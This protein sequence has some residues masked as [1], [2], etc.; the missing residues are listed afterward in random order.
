[1]LAILTA[2][3]ATMTAFKDGIKSVGTALAPAATP[4]DVAC[5]VFVPHY[6][7]P[8]DTPDSIKQAKEHNAV[9]K[10]LCGWKPAEQRIVTK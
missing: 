2:S 1:M 9:G 3:C 5:V 6:S 4:T 10:E 7:S 8:N